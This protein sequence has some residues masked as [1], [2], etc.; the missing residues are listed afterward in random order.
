LFRM[1][2]HP[3]HDPD[4]ALADQIEM[5][6]FLK[7]KEDYNFINYIDLPK[8]EKEFLMLVQKSYQN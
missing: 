3:P 2:I 1:A 8:M 7:E 4:N 5:I 6:K